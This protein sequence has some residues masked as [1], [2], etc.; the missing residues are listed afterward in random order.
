[1]SALTRQEL[2]KALKQGEIGPLYL[3]FGAETYLRDLAARAISDAT[4]TDA[5]LREFNETTFSLTSADV[6]QAI[7][8]AEQLPM[9]SGR[10]HFPGS[11][12][13]QRIPEMPSSRAVVTRC[14]AAGP[15]PAPVARV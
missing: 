3:L 14:P 9:M 2:H 8:A 7:A 1:M 15:V 10:T 11:T 12:R 5:P 13:Y 6:Q 4:L